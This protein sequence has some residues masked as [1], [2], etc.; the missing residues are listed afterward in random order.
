MTFTAHPCSPAERSC[1]L[2]FH[3]TCRLILCFSLYFILASL[4]FAL[5]R[6][7]YFKLKGESN[8]KQTWLIPSGWMV[9][10]TLCS[11]VRVV[12]KHNDASLLEERP[13]SCNSWVNDSAS[14]EKNSS[15]YYSC[16][17]LF[18]VSFGAEIGGRC[19]AQQPW[20]LTL[21]RTSNTQLHNTCEW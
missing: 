12:N 10:D 5:K 9:I 2:V 8:M 14:R 21:D 1:E 11:L 6:I 13:W 20:S 7:L 16:S 17:T 18:S 4:I 3:H 15:Q 19:T